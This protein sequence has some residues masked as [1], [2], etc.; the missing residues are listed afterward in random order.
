M[1]NQQSSSPLAGSSANHV[2][3]ASIELLH[4]VIRT[5][6]HLHELGQAFPAVE[7]RAKVKW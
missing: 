2:S 7:Y 3:W 4:N 5:L 6:T 1:S